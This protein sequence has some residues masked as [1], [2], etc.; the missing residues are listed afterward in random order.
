MGAKIRSK[1]YLD[2]GKS[3]HK[4][5]QEGDFLLPVCGNLLV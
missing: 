1:F 2:C 3:E 4:K 5:K